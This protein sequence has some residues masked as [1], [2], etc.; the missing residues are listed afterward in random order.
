MGNIGSGKAK[1]KWREEKT[2][3]Y[4]TPGLLYVCATAVG[5]IVVQGEDHHLHAFV[6][7]VERPPVI[8]VCHG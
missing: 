6:C 8:N 1:R 7:S 5:K 4:V 2:A 3:V